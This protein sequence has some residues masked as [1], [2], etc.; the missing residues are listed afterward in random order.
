[1][2]VLFH[3]S[4]TEWS[5]KSRAFLDAARALQTRGHQVA[6]A[7]APRSPLEMRC[8]DRGL[9]TALADPGA[10]IAGRVREFRHALLEEFREVLIVHDEADDLAASIAVRSTRRGAVVRRLPCGVM[11][12]DGW[13]TRAARRLAPVTYIVSGVT[14]REESA[15][16]RARIVV[17]EPGIDA[18][19]SPPGRMITVER[20]DAPR[21]ACIATGHAVH[22]ILNVLRA[23][24]LMAERHPRVHLSMTGTNLPVDELKLHAA[25]LN[26]AAQVEIR[27]GDADE[28]LRHV[29]VA[30]V[31]A[32]A[33]DAAFGCLAAMAHALP[34][35]AE[36][37]AV[38]EHFVG[39]G[40]GGELFPRLQPPV[41]A[42]TLAVYTSQP[43][44]RLRA[45][46]AARERV[47]QSFS[48]REMA[49]GYERALRTAREQIVA[50]GLS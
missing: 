12:D 29:D 11:P 19:T 24:S 8:R 44:R 45:G 25:V 36:R 35:F 20:R 46:R 39:Q 4:S 13:R 50:E 6:V 32:E 48:E 2:T 31:V 9:P 7:C 33:D 1:M 23:V 41:M 49:S 28:V 16:G 17:A 42:A 22:R 43:A 37:N 15:P 21:L 34:V 27:P 38:T 26:I 3:D 47:V 18:P 5:G 10:T 14:V 30:W 40:V